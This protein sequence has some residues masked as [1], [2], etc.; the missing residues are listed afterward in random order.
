M[1][2]QAIH[3][4]PHKAQNSLMEPQTAQSPITTQ[5]RWIELPQNAQ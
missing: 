2:K 5:L 1:H 4:L 3:Q